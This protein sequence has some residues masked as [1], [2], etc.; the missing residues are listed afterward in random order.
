MVAA[1]AP[2]I[3]S[4]QAPTSTWLRVASM[5]SQL[6][7]LATLLFAGDVAGT[8][9]GL[10]Y[11]GVGEHRPAVAVQQRSILRDPGLLVAVEWRPLVANAIIVHACGHG[12]AGQC[13]AL[14]QLLALGVRCA[15]SDQTVH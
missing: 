6:L 7:T 4:T 2:L 5:R 9:G 8:V 3:V 11:P 10:R 12:A 14:Q 15:F 1:G 13:R